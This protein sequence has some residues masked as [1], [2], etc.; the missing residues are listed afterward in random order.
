[1]G[2]FAVARVAR[3]WFPVR[4]SGESMSP[5]LSPGDWLAVRPL[6]ASEPHVGQ[7]VV[8]R[9]GGLEVVKRV[10]REDEA[11]YWLEGDNADASTD[12]RTFGSV[13]RADI[14]GVVRARY[15]PLRAARRFD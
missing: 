13:D 7:I 6:R 10:A 3:G 15:K 11:S 4:V 5:A 8:L 12:S 9:R 1:M 14:T 2:L